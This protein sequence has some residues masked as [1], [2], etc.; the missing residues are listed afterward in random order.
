MCEI[1]RLCLQIVPG[2]RALTEPKQFDEFFFFFRWRAFLVV[3]SLKFFSMKDPAGEETCQV[4]AEMHQF[5]AISFFT[6]NSSW[7]SP[8]NT[9]QAKR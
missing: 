2:R 7:T 6:T 8:V 5:G 4:K 3:L 1:F 9:L